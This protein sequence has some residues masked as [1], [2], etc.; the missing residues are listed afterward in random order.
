MAQ[1]L[2]RMTAQFKITADGEKAAPVAK[3]HP[4]AKDD[5]SSKTGRDDGEQTVVRGAIAAAV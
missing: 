1:E 4:T 2:Q 3:K 5:G